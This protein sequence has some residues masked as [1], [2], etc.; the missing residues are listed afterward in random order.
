MEMPDIESVNSIKMELE[1]FALSI[2]DDNIPRITVHLLPEHRLPHMMLIVM[3]ESAER[4][5]KIVGWLLTQT[6]IGLHPN[7]CRLDIAR[8]RR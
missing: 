2:L 7:M 8:T 6:S 5:R 4:H 1:T 3:T